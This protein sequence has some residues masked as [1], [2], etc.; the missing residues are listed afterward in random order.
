MKID[1]IIHFLAGFAIAAPLAPFFGIWAMA[2]VVI[3]AAAKEAYDSTGRGNVE[4]SDF[5]YTVVGGLLAVASS[6]FLAAV[7]RPVS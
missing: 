5:A 6:L 4:F 3:A 1:K 2:P 7:F